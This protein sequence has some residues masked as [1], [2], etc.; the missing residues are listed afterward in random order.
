MPA[1]P[2]GMDRGTHTHEQK[3][4]SRDSDS[5]PHPQLGPRHQSS[6]TM[7]ADRDSEILIPANLASKEQNEPAAGREC[8]TSCQAQEVGFSLSPGRE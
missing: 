2:S 3:L 6:P 5:D 1:E 4:S 7:S 8:P